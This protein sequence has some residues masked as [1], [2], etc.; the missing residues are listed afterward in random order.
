M[1]GNY[2]FPL[3][4]RYSSGELLMT[5]RP[6]ASPQ[7]RANRLLDSASFLTLAT[8]NDTMTPWASTVNYVVLR[9]PLRLV[10]YSMIQAQHSLN[11]ERAPLVSAS[12]FRTDLGD[13][14]PPAGL[15]GIQLLGDGRSLSDEEARDM[16]PLY[17]RL[18]FPDPAVRQ[19]WELPLG[20]F[21]GQGPRR[22]YEIRPRCLWLLDLERWRAD[23]VDQR[24]AVDIDSLNAS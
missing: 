2:R 4:E 17:Y 16:H 10:W 15:D 9:S 13:E 7:E 19:A 12:I 8:F 24:L 14:S 18:N 23:K 11:I 21:I 22:F 3:D 20:E 5:E 1:V 6:I